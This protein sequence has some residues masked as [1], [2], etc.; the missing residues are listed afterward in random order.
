MPTYLVVIPPNICL[1]Q[2]GIIDDFSSTDVNAHLSWYGVS[3]ASQERNSTFDW[4]RHMAGKW[5]LGT[6]IVEGGD[7]NCWGGRRDWL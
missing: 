6:S 1:I 3:R 2:R 7:E 5:T 4:A